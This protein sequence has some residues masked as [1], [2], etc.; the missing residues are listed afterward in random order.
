MYFQ[1]IEQLVDSEKLYKKTNELA[2]IAR[3]CRQLPN[4]RFIK[5]LLQGV[6][7]TST[8]NTTFPHRYG[9]KTTVR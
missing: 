1:N 5:K 9:L 4:L 2:E 8:A 3:L 7:D 6:Q